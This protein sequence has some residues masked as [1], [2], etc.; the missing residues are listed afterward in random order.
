PV[1]S[2]VSKSLL[3]LAANPVILGFAAVILG[4]Y[5]AW[6]NWDKITAIVMQL[7]TAVKTWV[8][9]KLNAVW[10][11]LKRKIDFVKG[12]FFGLYDAV[13]GNSYIPDMVDGIAAQMDRLDAV[14]VAPVTK[15]TSKAAKAFREMAA[16]VKDLL[17]RLFP[18]AAAGRQ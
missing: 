12:L 13:V 10:D 17:D 8:L 11:N 7:Y 16:E 15:A 4:I 2:I 9:D 3:L 6:K 14:M 5:L 1:I 18:E